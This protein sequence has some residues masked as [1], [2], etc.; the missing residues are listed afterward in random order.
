MLLDLTKINL[1]LLVALE[2]LLAT[3]SVGRAAERLGVSQSAMSHNLRQ[4][5]EMFED[6]LLVRSGSKMIPTPRAERLARRLGQ[7]L[8]ALQLAL[9]DA[10][11]FDPST[12]QRKFSIATGDHI[13]V[14]C[15]PEMLKI[16]GRSAPGIALDIR[17]IQRGIDFLHEQAHLLERG[18]VDLLLAVVHPVLNNLKRQIL[19]HEEFMCVV[20]QDHPTIRDT[21]TLEQYLDAHHALISVS[22]TSHGVIDEA[23]EA[24]GLHRRVSLCIQSFLAAPIVVASSDLI[25]TAPEAVVRH[26]ADHYPLRLLR[27]PIDVPGFD[28]VQ[29]WHE[30]S[31]QDDGNAWLRRTLAEIG[32][33]RAAP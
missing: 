9:E 2:A 6:E 7:G 30:R 16:V 11:P 21:L 10:P 12:A 4:L 29:L 13:A 28:V 22:G 25:L 31:D 27:P 23:L 24:K 20:R 26:F 19:W 32:R 5:R 14:T 8:E 33:N 17:S 1:N 15:L 18:E 3:K